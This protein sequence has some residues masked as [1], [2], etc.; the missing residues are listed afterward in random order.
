MPSTYGYGYGLDVRR[1]DGI[2]VPPVIIESQMLWDN[3]IT[4]DEETMEWDD[5]D[6][7]AV[8]ME[9]DEVA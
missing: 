8:S 5:E 6:G 9:W 4:G 3:D 2:W 7:I 1:D